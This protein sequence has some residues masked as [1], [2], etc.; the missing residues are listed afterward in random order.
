MVSLTHSVL[1]DRERGVISLPFQQ[2]TTDRVNWPVSRRPLYLPRVNCVYKWIFIPFIRGNLLVSVG[3]WRSSRG[4]HLLSSCTHTVLPD[5]QVLP[6]ITKCY[7]PQPIRFFFQ[8]C[9]RRAKFRK[10][11]FSVVFALQQVVYGLCFT[12]RNTMYYE[13]RVLTVIFLL[14]NVAVCLYT[15][16]KPQPS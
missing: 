10:S 15:T 6:G 2:P 5:Y 11:H 9:E 4:C 16:K 14:T 3:N 8:I 13:F 7:Q 12:K 1:R